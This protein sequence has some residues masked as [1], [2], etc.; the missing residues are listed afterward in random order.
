MDGHAKQ[1]LQFMDGADKRFLIP[2]YQRNYDWK[3]ANCRQL[4]TVQNRSER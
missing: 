4:V 2:V 3:V 1:L